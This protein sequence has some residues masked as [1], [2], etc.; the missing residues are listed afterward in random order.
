MGRGVSKTILLGS[1]GQDPEIRT[2]QNGNAIASFSL[3]TSESWKDKT[4]GEKIE[5]TEWHNIVIFGRLAEIAG[6]YVKK[7]SKLYL[8][9]KNKT[10]KY[11]KEGVTHYRTK[12]VCHELQMLDS[13]PS[14]QQNNQAPTGQS[15]S[16]PQ[17]SN[18]SGQPDYSDFDNS[19]IP[20]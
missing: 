15:Y 7:G 9:G 11:D 3:A 19:D 20:F 17:Q 2:S 16:Q 12:V 4:T 13:K 14:D 18:Q 5:K 10:D 1:V 8:E 6:Q